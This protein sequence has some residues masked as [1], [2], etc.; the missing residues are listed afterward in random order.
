MATREEK[1]VETAAGKRYGARALVG[2]PF[3]RCAQVA[4]FTSDRNGKL[5]DDGDALCFP[6]L[7]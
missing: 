2:K 4:G 3:E 5:I 7:L 6:T 1:V